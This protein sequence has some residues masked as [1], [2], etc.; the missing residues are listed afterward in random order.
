MTDKPS[1]LWHS[2]S[3]TTST[4][5]GQQ[6]A[7]FGPRLA[8]HYNLGFSAFYGVEGAVIPWHGL[9]IYP[10]IG[11]SHG[12][13]AI[14]DHAEVHHGSLRGGLT[15]S[16]M[17]VWV[18]DPDV[19]SKLNIAC[20]TPVD[21][22]PVPAPVSNFFARSGAVPIAMSEFGRDELKLAGLDPLYIP[23]AVDCATF[24]PVPQ[25]QAREATNMPPDRFIVGMV[26]ANKGNPSRKCFSEAFQAFKLLLDKDP[27]A[28]LY[29]HTEI[30][31][32]FQGVELIPLLR[33]VGIPEG[34]VI[35]CDQ[36][37][38]VHYPFPTEMMAKVYSSL[39]VL[40]APSAGEGF[41]IP[42]V[43]A[44]ACGVPVIVSD[45]SAQ[46]EL[47]GAGWLVSGRRVYTPIGS[48][49]FLPDVE[50]ITDA[51][52]R[53]HSSRGRHAE[54]A[55]DFAEQYHVEVIFK[56]R[57]LPALEEVAERYDERAP[58]KVAAA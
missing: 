2:N 50:D 4:G 8:E 14:K 32:R 17:D 25:D 3:P 41:G 39:D 58:L 56:D 7:L 11:Q 31:G 26:A 38:A 13:E 46:P 47:C 23:H 1:L 51:L 33:E 24:K 37:R 10:G 5:Y 19:W 27:D 55:R 35:A 54:R 9:P 6:T 49:Q 57:M 42:V 15:V 21:H 18:L 16:L 40:L 44:Q 12:N 52:Q 20:W 28:M 29:L 43:E 30:T 36:Y 45:F 34:S 22:Q 48:W 53:A